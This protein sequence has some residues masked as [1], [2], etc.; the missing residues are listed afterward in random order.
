MNAAEAVP[1]LL[2]PGMDG[3]GDLLAALAGALSAHRPP[4]VIAYP[5]DRPLGYE[6]LTAFVLERAPAGRFVILGESFSSPIAIEIAAREPRVAGLI[7]ASGFARHPAPKPWA[8]LAGAFD[9]RLAPTGL[10][11]AALLGSA[12]TPSLEA[13]LR[14]VLAS[15]APEVLRARLAEVLRVDKR[16]QL[17]ATTCPVLCLHGRR[18]RLVGRRHVDQITA[19]RSD[20]GVQWFDAPHMLLET[21]PREAAEAINAFC[22]DV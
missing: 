17:R 1:V 10:V 20:A 16:E 4:P 13:D 3:T 5:A 18:D 14:R 6:A 8:A 2:L 22:A 21:H 7:I 11:V 15:I 19:A 12:R 9:M